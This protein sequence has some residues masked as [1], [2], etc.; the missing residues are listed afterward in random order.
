M[1]CFADNLDLSHL[2][3]N[4]D[5]FGAN[6]YSFFGDLGDTGGIEGALEVCILC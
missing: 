5:G 1:T 3:A 6:Q 2:Q 4:G